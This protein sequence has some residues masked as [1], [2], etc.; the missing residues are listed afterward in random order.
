[1]CNLEIIKTKRVYALLQAM[2]DSPSA[3]SCCVLVKAGSEVQRDVR[4]DPWWQVQNVNA[5]TRRWVWKGDGLVH[6]S[7]THAPRPQTLKNNE[8]DNVCTDE[9]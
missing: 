2:V 3:R 5:G 4:R 9:R 7:P 8:D 1:M 6:K